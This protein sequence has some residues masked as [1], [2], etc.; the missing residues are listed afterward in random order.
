MR[1]R[2]LVM[3]RFGKIE[4]GDRSFD[5]EFW[6]RQTPMARLNAAWELAE[7]YH[8]GKGQREFRLQRSV[9]TFQRQPR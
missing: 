8:R 4:D 2:Q 1:K 5:I 9:E 3:E 6:Q 7:N